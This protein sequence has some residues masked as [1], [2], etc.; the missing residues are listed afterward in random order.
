MT[1]SVGGWRP[2]RHLSA[3]PHGGPDAWGVFGDAD[4]GALNLIDRRQVIDSSRLVRTGKVFSLSA[5]PDIPSPPLDPDRK[6]LIHNVN[7]GDMGAGFC[8][9]DDVVDSYY[10]QASSQWDGLGHV[11]YAG[12]TFYNGATVDEVLA[13]TRN[14]IAA[15]A[16]RGIVGRGVVVDLARFCSERWVDGDIGSGSVSFGVED[17]ERARCEAGLEF[18]SGCILLLHTG[19]LAWYATLSESARAELPRKL[20]VPGIEHT[21]DMAE[22]LWDNRIAAIAAD[23]FAVEVWPP[24]LSTAA[25]PFGFLHR[26][27]IGQFGMALGELW[28]LRALAADCA[29]D[30]V[31]ECMVVSAPWHLSGGV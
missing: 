6:P 8:D 11:A 21:E 19:F 20:Q 5:P 4:V 27:L 2:Y 15:W 18:G 31:Y 7:R 26:I 28:D 3:A 13:G 14:S 25:Q 17:L 23:N 16:R 29:V 10:P 9:L 24:D 1:G 30:G 12:D 22:Y